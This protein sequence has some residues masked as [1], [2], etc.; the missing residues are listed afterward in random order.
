MVIPALPEKRMATKLVSL[1]AEFVAQRCSALDAFLKR[2]CAHAALRASPHLAAFLEAPEGA[3][4]AQAAQ[5]LPRD[6]LTLARQRNAAGPLGAAALKELGRNAAALLAGRP[7]ASDAEY[8]RVSASLRLV[9]L[10]RQSAC[11][12]LL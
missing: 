9:Q 8:D 11:S 6:S 1:G 2:C 5:P 3:W 12:R 7:D 10:P 4:A